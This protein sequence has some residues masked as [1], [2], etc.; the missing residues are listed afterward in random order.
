MFTIGKNNIQ[1]GVTTFSEKVHHQFYMNSYFEKNEL[2]AAIRRIPY[3][4]G[5]TYTELA[6]KWVREKAF[7]SQSGDRENAGNI[8]IVMTD[9]KSNNATKTKIEAD[10]LHQ[11]GIQVFAIGIGTG[12]KGFELENIASDSENVFTVIGFDALSTIQSKLKQT[13]CKGLF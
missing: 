3:S 1:I 10:K 12:I 6:L 7:T 4:Q 13:T 9:G 2:L 11:A 8:L 5:G